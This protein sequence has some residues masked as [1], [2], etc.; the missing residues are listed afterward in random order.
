MMLLGTAS[1][2]VRSKSRPFV[3]IVLFGYWLEG[4]TIIKLPVWLPGNVEATSGQ[5]HGYS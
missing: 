4:I 2:L 5:V 3:V 1:R